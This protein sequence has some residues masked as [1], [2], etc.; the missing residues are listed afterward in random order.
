[1]AIC[2]ARAVSVVAAAPVFNAERIARL[3]AELMPSGAVP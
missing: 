3:A 2:A 1:M